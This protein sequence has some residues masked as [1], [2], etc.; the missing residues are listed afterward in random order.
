MR[1]IR[2]PRFT[3]T[4]CLGCL[5]AVLTSHSGVAQSA[6]TDSAAVAAVVEGFHAALAR[7]DS[8]TALALMTDDAVIL[9]SGGIETRVEYR[10]G[11]LAGDI[12]FA[13]RVSRESGEIV[14]VVR[15][16]VAWA[17]SVSVTTGEYR[18][19]TIDS[20]GAELAVLTRGDGKWKIRA[21]HWSSRARRAR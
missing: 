5:A 11:H 4:L 12:G 14:V 1:L 10:S 13:Q 18:G 17:T 3:A 20:R 9:E 6:A 21:V 16:D 7:G 19:R 15:Q 2:I 8:T